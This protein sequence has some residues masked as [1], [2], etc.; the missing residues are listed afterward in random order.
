MQSLREERK[1]QA[2]ADERSWTKP[3][4]LLGARNA[5]EASRR[6]AARGAFQTRWKA[7]AEGRARGGSYGHLALVCQDAL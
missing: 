1:S 6:S 2:T 7:S 5:S 4:A 3:G